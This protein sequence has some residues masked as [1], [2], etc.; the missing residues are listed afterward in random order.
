MLKRLKPNGVMI[1]YLI[2]LLACAFAVGGCQ[3]TQNA[4]NPNDTL[5]AMNIEDVNVTAFS[6]W[7]SAD[8][9]GQFG[10]G[11]VLERGS[12]TE[13][14]ATGDGEQTPV[15]VEYTDPETGKVTHRVTTTIPRTS[16]HVFMGNVWVDQPV[17]FWSDASGSQ[18]AQAEQRDRDD[19]G[20]DAT[21]NVPVTGQGTA[22]VEDGD[23]EQNSEDNSE[24]RGDTTDGTS[25]VAPAPTPEE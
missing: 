13:G 4:A 5:G 18:A 16:G 8:S 12:D 7:N 24:T 2:G 14:D 22:S 6:P 3:Q 25:N 1:C 15:T 9:K 20:V 21:A 10:P 19:L 17:Q 11:G 23:S